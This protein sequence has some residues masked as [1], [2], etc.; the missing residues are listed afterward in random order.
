[1]TNR[2]FDPPAPTAAANEDRTR[3]DPAVQRWL[4]ILREDRNHDLQCLS[5]GERVAELAQAALELC[6]SDNPG[7]RNVGYAIHE[8]IMRGEPERALHD[9][10]IIQR[11][12]SCG[13]GKAFWLLWRNRELERLALI[14]P[15]CQDVSAFSAAG[16]LMES[17]QGYEL[18]EW[19]DDRRDGRDPADPQRRLWFRM[20]SRGVPMLQSQ[21]FLSE[22]IG[23][24]V[25]S[26]RTAFREKRI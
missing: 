18:R 1:M 19:P 13:P 26:P 7:S 14:V 21:H 11:G 22:I 8:A 9:L 17:Y 15:E 6:N 24:S 10:N 2:R 5:L 20:L 23:R 4:D 25:P 3:A 12:G 16:I